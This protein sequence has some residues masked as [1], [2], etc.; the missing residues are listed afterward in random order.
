MTSQQRTAADLPAGTRVMSSEG[1][2]GTVNGYDI[3][4]VTDTDHPN[5]G[6]E[7]VGVTWDAVE[8]DKGC[9]RRGRPF[10]DELTIN[11]PPESPRVGERVTYKVGRRTVNA[12]VVWPMNEAGQGQVGVV[13]D[14]DPTGSVRPIA[15]VLLTVQAPD[16]DSLH[17][18]AL[19][20]NQLRVEYDEQGPADAGCPQCAAPAK[21]CRIPEHRQGC[22]WNDPH[23]RAI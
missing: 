23:Y 10:V 15:P 16:V 3:G 4:R 18:A 11:A 2:L 22:P 1:R 17:A 6:R 21:G 9:N 13:A 20:E 8:G 19:Y 12:T 5:C 14:G 7:Y